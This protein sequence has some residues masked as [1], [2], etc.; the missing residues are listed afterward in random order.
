M[1]WLWSLPSWQ[2]CANLMEC[3]RSPDQGYPDPRT[4]PNPAIRPTHQQ[5]YLD[6]LFAEDEKVGIQLGQADFDNF[7]TPCCHVFRWP[8]S[9]SSCFILD[10]SARMEYGFWLLSSLP[11][12]RTAVNMDLPFPFWTFGLSFSLLK[13]PPYLSPRQLIFLGE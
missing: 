5:P 13:V 7:T 1:H 4:S 8:V 3:S 2:I 11:R 10:F 6:L 9:S 12:R